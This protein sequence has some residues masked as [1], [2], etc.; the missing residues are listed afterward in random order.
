MKHIPR[1][2]L[3]ALFLLLVLPLRAV[4]VASEGSVSVD[5]GA[6][7][8]P[9]LGLPTNA[10]TEPPAFIRTPEDLERFIS[11]GQLKN[12]MVI[13]NTGEIMGLTP[14]GQEVKMQINLS[15]EIV[16]ELEKNNIPPYRKVSQVPWPLIAV[17]GLLAAGTGG[18]YLAARKNPGGA[19]GSHASSNSGHLT[20]PRQEE[21]ENS[22]ITFRD[23]A[24]LEEAKEELQE[25]LQFLKNPEKFRKLGARM[26]RGVILFG[27]PGTGK[28]LLA[29]ALAGEANAAFFAVS[30]SD[31]V[32]KY[33]GVGASRIRS[34]FESA[35]KNAPAIIFIDEIDAV[36]RKRAEDE[37]SNEEKDR[38]LNQL[39]V[40]MDGFNTSNAVVVIG[41]TNRLDMLDAALLRPGRFDRHI[42][43]DAPSFLERLEILK[44]H[45]AN[46]PFQGI[47]LEELAHRTSGLTGA[48]LANLCNE[49]AIIA[50]RQGKQV[51]EPSDL[52]KAIDR[53]TAG[54]EKKAHVLNDKEKEII[55]YHEGGHALITYLLQSET[56]CR[57]SIL[58][59]GRAMGFVLQAPNTDKNI[60]SR[61]DLLH[62]IMT[63]LGGRAAEEVIFSDV[64]TGAKNDLEKATEI[65]IRMVGEFGMSELGIASYAPWLNAYQIPIEVHKAAENIISKCYKQVMDMHQQHL[66]LL[67]RLAK[68]L[69]QKETLSGEEIYQILAKA[70]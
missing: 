40:E 66:Q 20:T 64:S 44:L 49:A 16:R 37:R 61:Q 35:R 5:S 52:E 21:K 19:A 25:I 39:L 18:F 30:G 57:I 41:A 8:D 3:L 11:A 59:R 23:V 9:L 53:V 67:H 54:V 15:Q 68:T 10:Q 24:G 56:L 13:K 2:M 65:A 26:P 22:T 36:G 38:T 51:I 6:Y 63:L 62:R 70:S 69:I 50:A 7:S 45:A 31:F 12:L 46:K 42:A 27:P 34:L 28:T 55:A 14:E 17:L 32:E 4:A 47:D 58:P 43:I 29:K 48:D 60:Y 33:V 1:I